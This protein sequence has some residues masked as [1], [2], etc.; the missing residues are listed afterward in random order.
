MLVFKC[1]VCLEV[2]VVKRGER[3][4]ILTAE[5]VEKADFKKWITQRCFRCSIYEKK[6]EIDITTDEDADDSDVQWDKAEE[7]RAREQ[8]QR[9]KKLKRKRDDA[10]EN[11][12]LPRSD[13]EFDY[14]EGAQKFKATLKPV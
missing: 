8:L 2:L 1:Y 3:Q 7:E 13:D 6:I 12:M 5:E 11:W 10:D 4:K 14:V 9:K